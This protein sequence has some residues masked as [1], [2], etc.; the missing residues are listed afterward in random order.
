MREPFSLV[1]TYY[2]PIFLYKAAVKIGNSIPY[3]AS[4]LSRAGQIVLE[5]LFYVRGVAIPNM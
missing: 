1:H 3:Q 4:V 2:L 5:F